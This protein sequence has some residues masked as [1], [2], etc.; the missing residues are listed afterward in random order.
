[1][2]FED[3]L[4]HP[5]APDDVQRGNRSWWSQNPMTYDWH[6]GINLAGN[7]GVVR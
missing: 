6:S 5:Q 3:S 7:T 2:K 1:M 4:S